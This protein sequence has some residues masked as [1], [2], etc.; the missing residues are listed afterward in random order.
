MVSFEDQLL[1]LAS[2]F[3]EC[4]QKQQNQIL[5]LL[6]SKCKPLQ[7]RKVCADLE[8]LLAVDVTACLPPE[9][10]D[11]IFS[12]LSVTDLCEVAK[13]NARWRECANSDVL[14]FYHCQRR[15]WLHY[16]TIHDLCQERPF[17]PNQ[18]SIA[19]TS[20]TFTFDSIINGAG[21]TGGGSGSD[22]KS[23]LQS[24][25]RW[26]EIYMRA[27]HLSLNWA[28][29]RYKV[30]PALRRHRETVTCMDAEGILLVSGS[31]DR[32]V[33]VWNIFTSECINVID[34]HTGA[35][36][37]LKMKNGLIVTGCSDRLLRVFEIGS[38]KCLKS[39][40][41]HTGSVDHV[42]FQHDFIISASSDRSVR[43]WSWPDGCC[44]H[45]L[46]GHSDDI[47]HL[48]VN[49]EKAV[50]TSWDT[51]VRV[52]DIHSGICLHVLHGHTE[53]VMCCKFDDKIIVSGGGEGHIKIWDT[54]VGVCTK[55]L[56][57]HS[58]EVY[59]LDY[60]SNVIASGSADSTVRLWNYEGICL[61]VM[62][63]HIGVVRCLRL[64]ENRLVT[65]G[66][67]KKIVVWDAQDGRLLNV[68]HRNPSLLHLM[69]TSDT[70]IIIASPEAPGSVTIFSY[71]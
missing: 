33:R 3:D 48:D 51:T 6:F 40:E 60:N 49:R 35:V 18:K 38:G 19:N 23:S 11:R 50:T 54:H 69:W 9:L 10:I 66:D 64:S 44:R 30:L 67:R 41:G 13:C 2:W 65:G 37:C 31:R 68:V 7:I 70:K 14:W 5:K 8:T 26:K 58:D 29:G 24:T 34:A 32:T 56:E 57:G 63:E 62:K 43:V 17:S 42:C 71:W 55:T 52:W 61:S 46:R 25:C 4:S 16:G 28:L 21:I 1:K 39:L 53:G 36:T 15:G 12:Y 45:V 47:Q 59:C 20:P 22:K 27:Y